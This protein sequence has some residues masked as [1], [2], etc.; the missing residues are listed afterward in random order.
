VLF[1]ERKFLDRLRASRVF[2]EL[3]VAWKGKVRDVILMKDWSL[4]RY[5]KSCALGRNSISSCWD[6]WTGPDGKIKSATKMGSSEVE[7]EPELETC[8]AQAPN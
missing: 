6:C 3:N 5:C 7:L 4:W 1:L 2:S 8:H